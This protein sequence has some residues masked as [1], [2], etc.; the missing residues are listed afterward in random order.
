MMTAT[1]PTPEQL[2]DEF[3]R[4]LNERL[5][6]EQIK[7]I[8]RRNAVSENP[9]CCASHDFCDANQAMIDA[10]EV[11]G[12]EFDPETPTDLINAAWGIAQKRGFA[13]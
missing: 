5:T 6:P 10:L 9:A 12:I 8:N 7:E 3:C 11:F 1:N 4:I 13:C 2:S